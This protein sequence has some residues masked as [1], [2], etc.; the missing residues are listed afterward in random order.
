MMVYKSHAFI[1]ALGLFQIS[2]AMVPAPEIS[3]NQD[4][5]LIQDPSIHLGLSG[6]LQESQPIFYDPVTRNPGVFCPERHELLDV[7]SD[8]NRANSIKLLFKKWPALKS[9]WAAQSMLLHALQ[10]YAM[11]NVQVLLE[12][13]IDPQAK[14]YYFFHQSGVDVGR[15]PLEHVFGVYETKFE[16]SVNEEVIQTVLAKIQKVDR[17]VGLRCMFKSLENALHRGDPFIVQIKMLL[18]K[19]VDPFGELDENTPV[20]CNGK[21][22]GAKSP[23]KLAE[24]LLPLNA[25]CSKYVKVEQERQRMNAQHRATFT[26]ITEL[27]KKYAQEKTKND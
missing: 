7:A 14:A 22:Y 17:V 25:S 5:S 15:S 16:P 8:P 2:I 18:D 23:A 3:K 24:I 26:A 1:M 27:F 19:D 11:P 21:Y 20:A 12:E 6:L 13:G 9:H 10:M 4:A